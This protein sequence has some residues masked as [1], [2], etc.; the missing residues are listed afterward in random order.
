M[1]KKIIS[2]LIIFC[3]GL[4]VGNIAFKDSKVTIGPELIKI[5]RML[6]AKDAD[7]SKIFLLLLAHLNLA[8]S[9][10]PDNLIIST[11][12][13]IQKNQKDQRIE[14]QLEAQEIITE[15]EKIIAENKPDEISTAPEASKKLEE[16]TNETW[17]YQD[18]QNNSNIKEMYQNA[19]AL[20]LPIKL[21]QGEFEFRFE[22]RRFTNAKNAN[23]LIL[24]HRLVHNGRYFNGEFELRLLSNEREIARL[25]S[26]GPNTSL[27]LSETKKASKVLIEISDYIFVFNIKK[28]N[29]AQEVILS[30]GNVFFKN[31]FEEVLKFTPL[32]KFHLIKLN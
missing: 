21:P 9:I 4:F 30:Q 6:D 12:V 18:L 2:L 14:D 8:H 10:N 28:L 24:K 32:G 20:V 23:R 13:E 7:Y 11:E 25:K 5:Q 3:L 15:T 22:S 27:L 16:I 26:D 29:S 17:Q 19:F 31:N 1:T